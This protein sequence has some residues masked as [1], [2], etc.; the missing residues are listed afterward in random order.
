MPTRTTAQSPS[1]EMS[2]VACARFT[3]VLY[4][5][6]IV[7]GL[8]SELYV[9]SGIIVR[10]DAAATAAN[11]ASHEGLF[12]TGF[13]SDLVAF[14]C[15]VAVAATL[16]VLLAG[17]SRTFAL[18]AAALR[19]TGTAIY[20][21]NLL[22]HFAALQALTGAGYLAAFEPGQLQAIALLFLDLHKYGYDLGLMFFGA[23]C[24]VLG[25]LIFHSERFPRVLGV[26][27]MLAS[28]GYLVGGLT[29]FLAPE[30]V[31]AVA[32]IYVVPLVGEVALCA[33]LLVKGVRSP[34]P[35]A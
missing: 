9:R 25:Y 32:P 1:I 34:L 24:L 26:L 8:F 28:V 33:W 17:V 16:Y 19:L 35:S 20:G 29:L 3:G 30:H 22:H 15:D 27:M 13:V 14:L 10:G 4:L 7:C 11:I 21:A 6:I 2:P 5:L 23:H 18:I 31:E 12:R